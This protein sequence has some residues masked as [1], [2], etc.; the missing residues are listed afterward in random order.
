MIILK[1]K[2]KGHVVDIPGVA[3]FRTPAEVDI[4]NAEINLVIFSLKNCGIDDFEITTEGRGNP[5][6]TV[7][8]DTI[9]FPSKTP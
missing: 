6:N 8:I 4:S 9:S 3:S 5:V 7:K 2:Q 1:V